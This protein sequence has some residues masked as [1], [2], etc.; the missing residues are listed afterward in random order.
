MT[1][2]RGFSAVRLGAFVAAVLAAPLAHAQPQSYP[3][4]CRGGGSLFQLNIDVG[5]SDKSNLTIS[6]KG[7]PAG[8]STRAPQ[9]GECAWLD[10]GW[11]SGEPQTMTWVGDIENL[12]LAFSP[13]GRLSS[14]SAQRAGP[15]SAQLKYL[16]DALR[17]G[18]TF[19][20]HAYRDTARS[21]ESFLRVTRVGP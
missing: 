15:Q 12:G 2:E 18:Q 4:A 13:D 8:A 11:R 20:V 10:R 7:A 9:R 21:G 14:I 17:R 19:Q 6:F 1:E 3:L 5:G 16:L